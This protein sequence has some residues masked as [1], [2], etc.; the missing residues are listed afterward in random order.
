MYKLGG[1]RPDYSVGGVRPS[2]RASGVRRQMPETRRNRHLGCTPKPGS[3]PTSIGLHPNK[4]LGSPGRWAGTFPEPVRSISGIFW[5]H[6]VGGNVWARSARFPGGLREAWG[7]PGGAS[8][9][10]PE[11]L[12]KPSGRPPGGFGGQASLRRGGSEVVPCL[13]WGKSSRL[14]AAAHTARA[15]L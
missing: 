6:G 9:A 4:C 7:G 8:R 3:M 11:I 15:T 5:G 1:W 13:T 12:R 2:F 14:K 10:D